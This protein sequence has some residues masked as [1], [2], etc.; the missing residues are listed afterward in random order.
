MNKVSIIKIPPE[1]PKDKY[2]SPSSVYP[3][4]PW[5]DVTING[6]N[7][8]YEGV[9]NLLHLL[10]LDKKKFGERDWNPFDFLIKPGYTVLL[11]PNMVK[12][13]HLDK[14]NEHEYV[15]THGA[16][17]RAVCDYIV[18]A[19]R[20]KGTIIFADAPET[21]ANFDLICHRNGLKKLLEF[22]RQ[23]APG[24]EFQVLDLRK[25]HWLKND[26]VIVEKWPLPGDPKGYTVVSL[27]ANSEFIGH[28]SNN[29]YFGATF[30]KEET[31]RH[32]HGNVHEYLISSSVLA[33]DVLINL[34]KLKTHKKGGLT[35]CLKN[36][37]GINGDKNW[38]PHHTEGTPC[39]GGDQFPSDSSKARLEYSLFGW[40]KAK[41]DQ[42]ELFAKVL[43]KIKK[44]GRPFFGS[45]ENV[46]RSGNWH[47]NDT[48]WRM[49]LDLN[50][51]VFH[52]DHNG[53]IRNNPRK[54]F[55]LVDGILAGEGLGPLQP[56]CKKL[57]LLVGGFNPAIVDRVC[58]KIMG[59]DYL[60]I[61][62]VKNAFYVKTLPFSDKA[63]S[64][65]IAS[66]VGV[67]NG[68]L[69]YL[70]FDRD[71]IFVPHF[72]WKDHIELRE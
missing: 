7:N 34:P 18:L 32:H 45:T 14:P 41:A 15:I 44:Y 16:V 49:I 25:E 47:G 60:K 39:M 71:W 36:M 65:L 23:H 37:V 2:Y 22:Y 17:I 55:C 31:K 53:K 70:A 24:I 38:L 19:L 11:K 43:G 3:E 62:V 46:I 20:G 54:M 69:N 61:P 27:D 30:A 33:A 12:E 6:I 29:D 1:Y 21:D 66:N 9:R 4:Y 56:D 63:E 13:S 35:C 57:G 48:V 64:V 5:Q 42:N 51:A 40:L 8:V 28:R 26:G 50:K 58:A 52:F 10:G 67:F 59:F 68:N 72:G